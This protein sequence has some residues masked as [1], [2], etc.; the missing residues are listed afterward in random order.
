[1]LVTLAVLLLMMTVIV[2]IFQAA[3][4]ALNA[5]QVYQQLDNQLRLLDSTIRSDL[6][7]VTCRMTP[8]NDPRNNPGYFE[9]GENEFADVQGEDSD[10]YIRFTAKAPA[11][12]PFTGRMWV[13]PAV[14]ISQMTATQLQNYFSSQPISITSEYAEII[15]FLRNGNLYRRVL[16]VAPERQ[17]SMATSVSP[18]AL[19][20]PYV[21]NNAWT[22]TD[23]ATGPPPTTTNYPFSPVALGSNQVSWQG[24]NDL[25]AHPAPRGSPPTNNPNS[26]IL[27]T[28]GDLTNRENRSFYQRFAD[29]FWSLA[30]A[31][32]GQDG[33][34]DDR[35]GDNVPDYYPTFYPSVLPVVGGGTGPPQDS[36]GNPI[37]LVCEPGYPNNPR[38]TAAMNTMAFPYVFPVAYSTPQ[39]LNVNGGTAP[40]GW[41]HSPGPQVN[42]GTVAPTP[43]T[44][45]G[46]ANGTTLDYLHN[47]NHNPLDLGD[48]L[49]IS[50]PNLSPPNVYYQ[51]WWGF[52][53]WRET[54]SPN[55]TDPTWQINTNGSQP[56][57]LAY[58]VGNP[59]PLLVAN[60]SQMLP[61]MTA[62]YRSNP[63]LFNDQLPNNAAPNPNGF[64]PYVAGQPPAL[65]STYSWEDDLI[66]TGVRSFDIKV[67]DDTLAGYA[68]LGWGD[69]VRTYSLD[70]S[71][72][73]PPQTTP[74]FLIGTPNPALVGLPGFTVTPFPNWGFTVVTP[75]LYKNNQYYDL[76]NQTFAH[77]GRMPP[78]VSDNRYDAQ[79]GPATYLPTTSPYLPVNP[80]G[81]Y[82]GNVGDSN[83]A[84][85]RL[86]R[87]WDSWSTEYTQ[88]PGTGVSPAAAAPPF[89]PSFPAGPPFTPPIYPS[90]PPPYPA[91]LRGIQIQI[92]VTDPTNQRIKSLTIRQ[93]FTDKL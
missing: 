22:Y 24:V 9:Y 56:L 35:N 64:F 69:D 46:N 8:P 12:R 53:T 52:P 91:P 23:P 67:Y 61:D 57:G 13:P 39:I 55:W 82:T 1:M 43:V 15:Y 25:S 74:P 59:A 2:Q 71:Q 37:Q 31:G 7:G 65:W 27:N 32:P 26:V 89:Y 66:M 10:D 40:Y 68:D 6:G 63:Q 78:L 75:Y 4:S 83:P 88:A 86:R 38:Q 34:S 60:T 21:S 54:L 80:G 41:I 70:N 77:E 17:R 5:A 79:F 47:L 28:L 29:D 72:Y 62:T 92:R 87:V 84:V 58:Q 42:I 33:L 3:T 90:Y 44:F 48:N 81:T 85:F 76:F 51:T 11:G 49:S 93:D 73:P 16:L 45:D 19:P 50:P 36:G 18:Q 30:L 20:A 14:P